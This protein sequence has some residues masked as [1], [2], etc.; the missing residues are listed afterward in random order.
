MNYSYECKNCG[1]DFTISMSVKKYGTVK[2]FCPVCKEENPNRTF[3]TTAIIFKDPGFTK[4]V[5]QKEE[6]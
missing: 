3:Q 4:Y 1:T 5:E 6:E 2:A